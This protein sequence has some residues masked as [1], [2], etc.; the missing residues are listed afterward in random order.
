MKVRRSPAGR[1]KKLK[2]SPAGRAKKL[3]EGASVQLGNPGGPKRGSWFLSFRD[4]ARASHMNQTYKRSGNAT[5]LVTLLAKERSA[6]PTQS[7]GQIFRS[8]RSVVSGGTGDDVGAMRACVSS[9]VKR[10]GAG[11]A[12]GHLQRV[13]SA[14]PRA[15]SSRRQALHRLRQH[16]RGHVKVDL[17][18]W[19]AVLP[20]AP[21]PHFKAR[22]PCLCACQHC[23]ACMWLCCVGR[24]TVE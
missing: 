16:L 1:A 13:Q 24:W 2:R 3:K 5:E 20:A 22:E 12:L 17:P 9:L 19:H 6:A 4:F 8:P 7:I 23:T 10:R 15:C 21:P 11:L 14:P 18:Q